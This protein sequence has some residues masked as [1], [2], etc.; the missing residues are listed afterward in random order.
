VTLADLTDLEL[1]VVVAEVDIPKVRVGLP[2]EIA[3]DALPG[4][5][6]NGTVSRVQPVS[7]SSN[8]VVNYPVSIRLDDENLDGVLPGM[9]AVATIFDKSVEPGWLVPSTSVHEFEG[10]HYVMKVQGKERVRV[11]VTP[12]EVQGEWTV[13]QSPDLKTGDE[14]VGQVTSFINEDSGFQRG[15]GPMGGRPR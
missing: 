10:E 1:N 9:T 15:F 2:V 6:F 13:V 7:E 11:K 4:R 5:M 3:I 12:G 8:G 14:V